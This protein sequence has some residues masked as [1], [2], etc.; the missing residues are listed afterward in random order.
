MEQSQALHAVHGGGGH[1]QALEVVHDIHL[2]ALQPGLGGPKAV[3]LDAEG[4]KLGLGQAVV[5]LGKLVLQHIRVGALSR[6]LPGRDMLRQIP[7]CAILL[8]KAWLVYC[9]PLSL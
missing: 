3:R 6:H 5:P 4:K 7:S 9:V 1:A 8:R 2:N